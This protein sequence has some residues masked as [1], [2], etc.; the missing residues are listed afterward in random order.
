MHCTP[1]ENVGKVCC[2][3]SQRGSVPATAVWCP[4]TAL[5]TVTGIMLYSQMCNQKVSTLV[6]V[7]FASARM[8]T[9]CTSMRPPVTKSA[10]TAPR[11]RRVAMMILSNFLLFLQ[12][13]RA[14]CNTIF[15]LFSKFAFFV[16]LSHFSNSFIGNLVSR[17]VHI[18]LNFIAIC[19]SFC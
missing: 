3:T 13:L 16:K 12:I 11:H 6:V 1:P 15:R 4:R 7:T 10:E 17:D 9:H 14:P 18:L 5:D 8:V 19:R 2:G